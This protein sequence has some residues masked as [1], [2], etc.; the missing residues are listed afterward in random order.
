MTQKKRIGTRILALGVTA[1]VLAA[2]GYVIFDVVRKAQLPPSSLTETRMLVTSLT[3]AD[4]EV[5]DTHID[6][7]EKSEYVSIFAGDAGTL[8]GLSK[9]KAAKKTLLFRY[10][11][12]QWRGT[13]PLITS[14]EANKVQVSL[15]GVSRVI[16]KREIWKGVSVEYRIGTIVHPQLETN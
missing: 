8:D 6:D 11:P 5:T 13:L 14:T 16:F 3:G 2:V 4:F 10:D 9:A 7:V 15:P 12:G 1:V